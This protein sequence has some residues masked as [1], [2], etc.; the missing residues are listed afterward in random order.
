MSDW[1][2]LG[3]H[4]PEENR[5]LVVFRV[6]KKKYWIAHYTVDHNQHPDDKASGQD[7]RGWLFQHQSIS[8]VSNDDLWQYLT[9][10]EVSFTYE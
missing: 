7:P 5:L 9:P 6:R 10:V 4:P 8:A 1:I 3:D 2:R